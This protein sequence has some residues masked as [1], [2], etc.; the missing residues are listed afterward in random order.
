MSATDFAITAAPDG[1]AVVCYA[2]DKID[3]LGVTP[4][5]LNQA[6]IVLPAGAS[7]GWQTS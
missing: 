7:N 1:H 5:E 6:A 2:A 3:L 4:G